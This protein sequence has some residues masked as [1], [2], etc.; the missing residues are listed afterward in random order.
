[1]AA[2]VLNLK[3]K[4]HE[5]LK[6]GDPFCVLCNGGIPETYHFIF[7]DCTFTKAVWLPPSDNN[8]LNW[9]KSWFNGP[10]NEWKNHFSII[11]WEIWNHRNSIV[12]QNAKANPTEFIKSIRKCL[13]DRELVLGKTPLKNKVGT[14]NKISICKGL[15]EFKNNVFYVDAAFDESDGSYGLGL[16]LCKENKIAKIK[17]FVGNTT[18]SSA[19]EGL[20]VMKAVEWEKELN[21]TYVK[22][23]SDCMDVINFLNR[24]Q[25]NYDWRTRKILNDVLC[26]LGNDVLVDFKYVNRVDNSEADKLAKW[27]RVKKVF[28]LKQTPNIIF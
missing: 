28:L 10:L 6:K 2:G 14:K 21:E 15:V 25:A 11:C 12:F 18:S 1:M 24:R 17:V 7:N 3:A 5:K 27:N 9:V 16:T 22:I 26:F 8:M 4:M 20:A 23:R 19:A 13:N